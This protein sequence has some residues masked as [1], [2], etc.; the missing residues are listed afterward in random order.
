MAEH[1]DPNEVCETGLWVDHATGEVVDSPPATG[2]QLVPPGGEMRPDRVAA[3]ARAREGAPVVTDVTD[4]PGGVDDPAKAA[5]A[6]KAPA[7]KAAAKRKG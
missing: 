1:Q 5:P 2:T 4:E 7:K 6:K 3:V